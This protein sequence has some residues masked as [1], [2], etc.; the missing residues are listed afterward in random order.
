MKR[1]L[2]F[3]AM[4][5]FIAIPVAM[6]QTPDPAQTT[7]GRGPAGMMG[8]GM[9]RGQDMGMGKGMGMGMRGRGM[10]GRG[11]FGA[12]AKELNL[13][14][15]QKAKIEDL[16]FANRNAMIDLR[17][18]MQKAHLKMQHE[19]MADTPDKARMLAASKEVN[20][21]QGQI[22][23]ARINHLFAMR[24]ILTPDQLKKWKDCRGGMRMGLGLGICN[25][26]GPR[27]GDLD[28]ENEMENDDIGM[29]PS[30][31]DSRTDR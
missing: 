8:M 18:S 12:C 24:A 21:I 13:T 4:L 29:Q 5:I 2:V 7:S 14:D 20:A 1:T 28:D 9:H 19:M 11:G 27:I 3:L 15:D 30:D 6:G 31:N 25:P 17:A 10:M 22:A 26:S 23:D 16:N